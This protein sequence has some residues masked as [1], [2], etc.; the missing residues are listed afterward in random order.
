MIFS[1]YLC[2]NEI[3]S[4]N[5]YFMMIFVVIYNAFIYFQF[6][7]YMARREIYLQKDLENDFVAF[8]L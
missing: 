6:M 8:K 2:I 4:H 7:T 5:F 1:F 3:W